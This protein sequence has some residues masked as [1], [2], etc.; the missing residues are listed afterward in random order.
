MQFSML[1][2]F[3]LHCFGLVCCL[4]HL[5]EGKANIINADPVLISNGPLHERSRG[6]GA[7]VK[8][9]KCTI[10][11]APNKPVCTASCPTLSG[12]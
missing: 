7:G 8:Q 6:G 4:F 1:K 5:A 2:A 11:R 9:N 12:G 3:G 10:V